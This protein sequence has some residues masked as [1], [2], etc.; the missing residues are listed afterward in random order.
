MFSAKML[1]AK[2]F[3]T[4]LKVVVKNSENM[5]PKIHNFWTIQNTRMQY[6][7]YK[8]LHRSKNKESTMSLLVRKLMIKKID[9]WS[10]DW[11]TSFHLVNFFVFRRIGI[12]LSPKSAL[13]RRCL[14]PD[15]GMVGIEILEC[16]ELVV[17]ASQ[18]QVDLWILWN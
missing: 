12:F 5:I 18:R 1:N 7:F 9:L 16:G 14:G 10:G 2:A 8:L 6:E 15:S 4:P 11:R 3:R 17:C 13:D